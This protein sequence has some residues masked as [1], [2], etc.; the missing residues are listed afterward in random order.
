VNWARLGALACAVLVPL[1]QVRLDKSLGRHRASEEILYVWSGEDVRKLF[2]GLEL[3]MADVYWIR[4]VQYFGG[5]RAFGKEK[6]FEILEP[7]IDITVTLDPRFEIA[8]RYGATFL[9]EP[10]PVG[11]G[12][13]EQGVRLLERGAKANPSSWFIH[14]NLGFF[15]YYYLNDPQRAARALLA[16]SRLPGA[17]PW[18]ETMSAD[19]MGRSGD[20]KTARAMWGRMYE[21]GEEGPLRENARRHLQFLDAADWIDELEARVRA[22]RVRQGRN[23]ESL[24][25]LR[26]AGMLSGPALDPAGVAFAYDALSGSVS[27]AR[28]SPLWRPDSQSRPKS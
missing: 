11:A 7:L 28:N 21:Q 25:E 20:R 5:Q 24:D 18:L 13:P 12:R 14:Q 23:P 10:W 16:A 6:K 1:L 27:V 2:P 4:T 8:Y 19:F 9:A 3:L 22:F 15:I 26:R 17:P